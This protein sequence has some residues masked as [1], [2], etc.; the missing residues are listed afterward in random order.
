VVE[1]NGFPDYRYNDHEIVR[2][3]CDHARRHAAIFWWSMAWV[4]DQA[5]MPR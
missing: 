2:A 3:F 4:L 5:P 1:P